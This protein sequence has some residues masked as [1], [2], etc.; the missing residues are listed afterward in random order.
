LLITYFF[1]SGRKSRLNQKHLF[2]KE[3]FYGYQALS[4]K[5]YKVKI[6][7]ESDLGISNKYN[8]KVRILNKISSYLFDLPLNHLVSF[9]KF[10]NLKLVNKSSII[11]AVTTSIGLS[12]GIL[13]FLGLIKK[14]VF[15]VVMG[16]LPLKRNIFKSFIYK[17]LLKDINIICLSKNERDFLKSKLTR[18]KVSYMPFGVDKEF[19]NSSI[20]RSSKLDY[21]LAI[22]ND[23]ARDWETLID[24]WEPNFPDLKIVTNLSVKNAK[25]NIS[26][27]KGSWGN[28][29]LSDEEIRDLYLN[30]SF[31][32]IPL[33]NTIQPS[34]QSCCLQAMSCRKPVIMSQIKGIWDEK[35]L[36][37]KKNI[38]LVKSGSVLELQNSISELLNSDTLYKRLSKEGRKLVEKY[39]NID[40]MSNNLE[41][42]IKNTF[43][44]QI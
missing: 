27:I 43:N 24:A 32:V 9:I 29:Y 11:I 38:L 37:H 22:G 42:N 12:L 19:W 3:F 28:S 5:G 7:E 15:F 21:I 2:P 39:F 41:I 6:I 17:Y 36:E 25:N 35:L 13:K 10:K 18:S 23:Y 30:A 20:K 16:L 40:E 8:L 34:G 26:I 31:V 33:K 14:P 1:K 44:T 4:K